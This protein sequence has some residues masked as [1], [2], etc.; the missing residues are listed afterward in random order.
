MHWCGGVEGIGVE[1]WRALV[2]R[3]MFDLHM[4]DYCGLITY[5]VLQLYGVV[6]KIPYSLSCYMVQWVS[7][8]FSRCVG[9]HVFMQSVWLEVMLVSY[10]LWRKE[11]KCLLATTKQSNT[12]HASRYV[13]SQW[14]CIG[15]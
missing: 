4:N 2:F 14:C 1:V 8:S 11:V 15:S 7:T 13:M 9:R 3:F 6:L 10:S 12:G 5:N